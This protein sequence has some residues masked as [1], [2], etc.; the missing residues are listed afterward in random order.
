M[1]PKVHRTVTV[2]I[3]HLPKMNCRMLSPRSLKP[4]SSVL[5]SQVVSTHPAHQRIMHSLTLLN[6]KNSLEEQH[7][8]CQEKV[9]L[10][11]HSHLAPFPPRTHHSLPSAS[12]AQAFTV[13]AF[14]RAPQKMM[15]VVKASPDHVATAS[16]RRSYHMFR[17]LLLPDVCQSFPFSDAIF[18]KIYWHLT[19][20]ASWLLNLLFCHLGPE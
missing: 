7:H 19:N 16:Y 4:S 18:P 12:S 15:E 3:C 20:A 9:K 17:I 8:V 10:T 13:G 5:L 1:C 14:P 6:S 2:G 11:N